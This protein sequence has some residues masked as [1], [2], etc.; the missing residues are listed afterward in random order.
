MMSALYIAEK[1]FEKE[2]YT[3]T[4]LERGEYEKCVFV[5]CNF[6]SSDLSGRVFIDCEFVGCD[7]SMAKTGGTSFNGVKF[8]GCKMLGIHFEN[9][10]DFG[11]SFSFEKCILN[12]STFFRKKIKKTEFDAC[13]L[14]ECDFTEADLTG[15]V[16]SECDFER[17]VLSGT[18]LEKS[19]FRSSYNYS[20]DPETSRIKKAK[21]SLNGIPGL[22]TKYNIT[23]E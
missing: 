14:H 20:I 5:K 18:N 1:K 10:N 23:I 17:A 11:L 7:L 15:S 16:F 19:D 3:E 22:L 13:Q 12:H 9:C 6:Y 2:D 4:H 21:F 8:S